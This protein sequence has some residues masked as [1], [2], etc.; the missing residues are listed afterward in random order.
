[1]SNRARRVAITSRGNS[2][3]YVLARLEREGLTDL[4]DA[5]RAREVSAY[6]VACELG[7]A[8]RRR[9]LSCDDNRTRRRTVVIEALIA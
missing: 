8:K 3:A 5:I 7:W 2:C 6:A 9:T 4:I 1:M